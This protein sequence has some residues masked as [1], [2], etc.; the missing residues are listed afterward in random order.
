VTK[1]GE[2]LH[3]RGR[4]HRIAEHLLDG[5]AAVGGIDHGKLARV[6]AQ[7]RRRAPQQTRALERSNASPG[8]EAGLGR[9][10]RGLDI[11]RRAVGDGRPAPRRCRD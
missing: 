3:L 7:D 5:I 4:D 8:L 2:E 10:D 11:L 6:L 1:T 9:R